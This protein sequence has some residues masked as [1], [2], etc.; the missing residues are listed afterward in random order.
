VNNV[1]DGLEGFYPNVIYFQKVE[2]F[3]RV[4]F[5]QSNLKVWH[6]GTARTVLIAKLT[7]PGIHFRNTT[8]ACSAR[9]AV[10][11]SGE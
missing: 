4:A 2:I 1:P 8:A 5:R 11:K 7:T 3:S 10:K 6:I 9:P